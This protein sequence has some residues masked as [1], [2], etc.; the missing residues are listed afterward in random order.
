MTPSLISCIVPVFNG[1][2]YLGEALDSVL[3]QTYSPLELI[4]ADDGSTD[5]TATI[6]DAYGDR[7]RYLRQPNSGHAAPGTSASAPR[8]AS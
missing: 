6:V 8:A 3:E 1:E 5:R 4:V 7:V 2:A